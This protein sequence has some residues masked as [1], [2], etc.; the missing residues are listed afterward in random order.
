MYGEGGQI[1]PELTGSN[2]ADLNYLLLNILYPSDDIADSY[3]MVTITTKDGRTLAGNVSEE[4]NQKVVL[5]MIGQKTTI[6]KGDIKSRTVA[7]F[8]MMPAGLLQTL[9]NDNIVALFKYMQ[10]KQQVSLT[11]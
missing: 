5:N 10:T 11:K 8:S 3:K 4:D 7:D 9:T 2:R 1:G 6:P